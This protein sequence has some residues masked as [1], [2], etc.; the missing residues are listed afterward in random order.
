MTPSAANARRAAYLRE[1]G[2][3]GAFVLLLLVVALGAPR[4]FAGGNLRDLAIANS[5]VLIVAVGMTLVL[6][7]GHVDISVGSQFAIGSVALAM[8]VRAGA[9][10]PAAMLIVLLGGACLG[11]L[12]GWLVAHLALPSVVVTLATM[13]IWRDAL[14]WVTQGAWV[15]DLPTRFQWFGLTQSAGELTVVVAA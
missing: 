4:F 1:L 7:T 12:N 11:A 13:V 15:Q 10:M 3:A 2:A 5:P 9:P 6:L 14:R 8:L